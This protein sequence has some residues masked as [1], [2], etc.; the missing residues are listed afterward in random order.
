MLFLRRLHRYIVN[1][2]IPFPVNIQ[3]VKLDHLTLRVYL[4]GI[5]E[6]ETT[7]FFKREITS[8][9]NVLDI[10]ARHGYFAMIFS[11]LVGQ[12]GKVYAF[13]PDTVSFKQLETSR[14]ANGFGNIVLVNEAVGEKEGIA[15][16]YAL[17]LGSGKDTIY[18]KPN[19]KWKTFDQKITTLDNYFKDFKKSIDFI[20]IDVEGAELDVLKGASKL[21]KNNP[22][23]K[24][25]MEFAPTIIKR[26]GITSEEF[27]S[28]LRNLGFNIYSILENGQI[29]EISDNGLLGESEIIPTRNIVLKK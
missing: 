15:K 9:A 4:K 6:A 28:T 18:P 20:K 14:R 2:P 23:I 8:G 17:E 5:Y 24:I 7:R 26:T 13:E 25:V 29:K 3:G 10:G 27:L 19:T 21:L 1:W 11:K 22:Q 16:F 12:V